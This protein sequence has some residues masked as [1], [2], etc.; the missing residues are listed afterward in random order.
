LEK[1]EM[2]DNCITM[3]WMGALKEPVKD[4]RD[5]ISEMLDNYGFGINYE[6]TLIYETTMRKTLGEAVGIHILDLTNPGA[7]Y[8][9]VW[10]A[11]F[12]LE[13]DAIRPFVDLWYNGADTGYSEITLAQFQEKSK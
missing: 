2:S 12:A 3:G 7:F 11:G 6:G 1:E 4:D 9:D 5:A 10:S 8:D 13:Q